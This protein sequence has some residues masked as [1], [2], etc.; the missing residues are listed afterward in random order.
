MAGDLVALSC[1]V[2]IYGKHFAPLIGL[3]SILSVAAAISFAV[4]YSAHLLLDIAL[5]WLVFSVVILSISGFF[6][7]EEPEEDEQVE[8]EPLHNDDLDA[9]PLTGLPD[10]NA[11][12]NSFVAWTQEHDG[13]LRTSDDPP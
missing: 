5:Y 3:P 12:K 11:L 2:F 4:L 9:A 8:V 6:N 1:Y 13:K 10:R 7:Y